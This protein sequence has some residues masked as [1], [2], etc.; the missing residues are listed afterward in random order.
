M[1]ELRRSGSKLGWALRL[2]I[3]SAA[4]LAVAW[5][6]VVSGAARAFP[7]Q[8]PLAERFAAGDTHRVFRQAQEELVTTKGKIS[9]QT[10]E[11]VVAA[12][13]EAPLAA[14][15][16]FIQGMRALSA[17][18]LSNGERLLTEARERH[19]RHRL[20]RVLLLA[21]YVQT[22]RAALAA[23]E[24]AVV[25]RLMPQASQLLVPEIAKLAREPGTRGAVIEAIGADPLMDEVLNFLA[26]QG[27][28][29]ELLQ[30]LAVRRPAVGQ[31]R[32]LPWQ[33]AAIETSLQR[34]G[35][36]AAYALWRR[37]SGMGAGESYLL[38]DPGFEGRPGGPPF[39]WEFASSNV[40]SAERAR[41]SALS[42]EF[43]GRVS[44]PLVSQL[45]VLPPGRY[46]LAFEAEGDA[47]DGSL[48]WRV[49]CR[50]GQTLVEIPLRGLT[51][52]P[53]PFAGEFAVP[54]GG[55]DGQWLRLEGVAA[56]F[57]TPHSARITGLSLTRSGR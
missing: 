36:A 57:A 38:Y 14:D 4:A 39:N 37:F 54:A 44:G 56:E 17:G 19:P 6:V 5:L 11:R 10:A 28:E 55:C 27:A 1:I 16:F 13:A 15:P 49:G 31:A 46:R 48:K 24:I 45:L 12:V 9:D 20:V 50:S 33:S 53:K 22:Q 52:A 47:K 32:L 43:F 41:G 35:V 42:I 26:A 29:P 40:G 2:L 30:A 21:V 51:F 8:S 3:L 25:S 23:Q 7:P 34:A 18:N